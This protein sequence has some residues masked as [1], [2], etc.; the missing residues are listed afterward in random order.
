VSGGLI[1]FRIGRDD[2]LQCR[3]AISPL[4]ETCAAV[5][6]LAFPARHAF[7]PPWLRLARIRLAGLVLDPLLAV[8]PAG[9][10][11]P[12]FLIPPPTSPLASIDE[13]LDRVRATPAP[14]VRRELR[15]SMQIGG[16]STAVV[17]MLAAPAQA[18]DHLADLLAECF[19]QLV[20][21]Y[22]ARLRDVLDGDIRYRARR[23]A[24]GGLATLLSD[25]HPQVRYA[26]GSV[27]IAKSPDAV[28][29]IKDA[30]LLLVPSAFTWPTV[31]VAYDPPWQ[32]TIVYPAR[33]T[34]A[35][36]EPGSVDGATLAR[37]L[38][39]TRARLLAEL[40]EPATTTELAQRHRMAPG[41]LSGHLTALRDAGL[42]A[43]ERHGRQVRYERTPLGHALVYAQ[44][45]APVR[46]RTR[47]PT[48]TSRPAPA[49]GAPPWPATP[50]PQHPAGGA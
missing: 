18:R 43:G 16:A 33:G 32:P 36:W 42:V 27:H 40:V 46:A 1:T 45:A 11:L 26:D 4:L 15:W 41:G 12:D 3:F 29:R 35:L 49:S 22:W 34:G 20:A 44:A 30:G 5:R 28:R 38:G 14:V 37:L 17:E 39:R 13:E 10:Y 25:L 9:G 21:P 47:T 8:M 24:A 7:H 31:R 50:Q 6:A 23:L 2:L 19:A 48:A